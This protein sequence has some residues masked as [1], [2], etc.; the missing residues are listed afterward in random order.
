[1]ASK[2]D[3]GYVHGYYGHNTWF[4]ERVDGQIIYK[5]DNIVFFESNEQL[6]EFI[7]GL[8]DIGPWEPEPIHDPIYGRKIGE[9]VGP[10]DL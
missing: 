4:C 10:K 1:M 5:E 7:K 9:N 6:E 8:P 2:R 3:L